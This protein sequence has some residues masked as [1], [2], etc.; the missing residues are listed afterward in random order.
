MYMT[1]SYPPMFMGAK[2]IRDI[3][4]LSLEQKFAQLDKLASKAKFVY[5]IQLNVRSS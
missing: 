3:K 5:L 4:K 2:A 1:T